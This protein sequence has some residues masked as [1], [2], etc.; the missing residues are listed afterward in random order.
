MRKL[1]RHGDFEIHQHLAVFVLF[2]SEFCYGSPLVQTQPRHVHLALGETLNSL[3]V[4]WSTID[5]TEESIAFVYDEGK[6]TEFKGSAKKFVDGGEKHLVQWIHK[7]E[8][9]GLKANH[10]Y[11]YRVGS[12]KGWSDVL[13]MKTITSGNN[14]SPN[15]ALFG[16]MGNENA[17][18]LPFIQQ[19]VA[20][21]KYDAVIHVGDMAYDMA[22]ENGL[23]GDMFMEQ[24]EPIASM[25]PYM[26]CPGNHEW[27]YNFS[28]YKA[29]FN[30]PRDD[31]NMF[32]SFDIGPIHF[33]SIS[34]E[35]YY[36]L[37]YGLKQVI[38]QYNWIEKDL[39]N[40]DRNIHPWIVV[41]GH[42]PMYCTNDDRDDCTK[43]ETRTR[44]G[45]PLI[46]LWG[47]EDLFMK[48]GVDVAVWAHEHSYERLLPTYNRTVV[49]GPHDG[50]PYNDPAAPVHITTGSAGCREK[51]DDFPEKDPPEWSAFRSTDYGYTRMI[52]LNSTH[53]RL[54]QVS[55]EKEGK[56]IDDLWIVQSRHGP[57]IHNKI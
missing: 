42:R 11:R 18:S 2:F 39:S 49:P 41:F 1:L 14:W 21:G 27:H 35:F 10:I 31:E 24:I 36:F 34:T 25:V 13:E 26:T 5:F 29:R 50:Q 19:E 12:K 9:P 22:E 48:Y 16:D 47:L 43:F 20:E 57:F 3:S 53:M 38:L 15:L 56:V 51:H 17:V 44:T 52:A 46:H 4:T 33:V 30:M 55:A 28:N 32:Y 7:V 37:N 54:Q 45:L 8:L 6:E 23:R 40:V